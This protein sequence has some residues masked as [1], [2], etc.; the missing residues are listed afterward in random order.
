MIVSIRV[1]GGE[2][3]DPAKVIP[4]VLEEALTKSVLLLER[5]IK[6]KV[7][8]GVT[9]AARGSIAGEVR[10]G[11]GRTLGS[12]SLPGVPVAMG[13]MI[14][15]VGSPLPYV[16]V[17]NDGRRPGQPMPPPEALELWVRRKIQWSRDRK[18][19]RGGR[20][21]LT[22]AEARSIAFVI[23]R[24]IGRRGT[25]GVHFYEEALAANQD[26]IRSFF[27]AAGLKI[28]MRLTQPI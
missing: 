22:T 28:S 25:K 7:P 18:G 2:L 14:G 15:I 20:Q 13:E 10:G 24:A 1:E 9:G 12:N 16:A 3:A 6:P 5:A 21:R 19:P 26:Q 27:E 17:I 11:S 23:A 8:M 4:A